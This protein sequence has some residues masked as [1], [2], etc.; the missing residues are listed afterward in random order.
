MGQQLTPLALANFSGEVTATPGAIVIRDNALAAAKHFTKPPENEAELV[1]AV[2]FIRGSKAI[3]KAVE[4]TRKA[5][6][7]PVDA[8]A[9]DIQAKAADF[10]DGLKAERERI[11]GY[12]NH[13]QK[14]LLREKEEAQ[15]RAHAEQAEILKRQN[16]IKAAMETA[17][18]TGDIEAEMELETAAMAIPAA[19]LPVVVA[20]AK[21]AGASFRQAF[22]FEV[23]NWHQL[24]LAHPDRFRWKADDESLKLDRRELV[25]ILNQ[26]GQQIFR[27]VDGIPQVTGCRVFQD[28]KSTYR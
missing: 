22:D 6:K 9:K 15:R 25:G 23:I 19:P 4:D 28:I 16:E 10:I 2:E 18:E 13:Y 14:K 11:D 3:E 21:M 7:G 17:V 1:Q 12:V 8:L 27:V 26:P 24:V 5:I 20:P